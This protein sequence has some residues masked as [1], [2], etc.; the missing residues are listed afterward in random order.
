MLKIL[1]GKKGVGKTKR[2][3]QMANE[4]AGGAKGNVVFIDDDNRYM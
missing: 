2:I 4:A 1:V 3:I